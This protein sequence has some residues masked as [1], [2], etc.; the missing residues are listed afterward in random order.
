MNPTSKFATAPTFPIRLE[1]L[2]PLDHVSRL[3]RCRAALDELDL[4]ALLVTKLEHIRYLA[5][6]SGS[7]ALLL[8]GRERTTFVSDGRYDE[9]SR[10]QLGSAGIDADIVIT[11]DQQPVLT[12]AATGFRRIGLE[13]GAVTWAAQRRYGGEWFPDAELVPTEGVIEAW[14]VVKEVGEAA[15]ME[16]AAAIADR[17]LATL[18]PRLRDR[19]SEAEFALELDVAMR[20][21]GASGPAFETI[22]ASGANSSRPHH[23]PGP[24]P[25]G[26]DDL[27]VVDF[28]ATVD[29]YRSDMTRTVCVGEPTAEQRRLYDVVCEAQ[30]AGVAAVRAGREAKEVDAACRDIITAAGWGER[31]P[32]GTGHGVGLEIHEAP[33]VGRTSAATL[34]E[35]SVVTVEPGVYL[36]GIGGVRTEDSV[37]VTA[38]GCR[39]LTLFPKSLTF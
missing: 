1:D 17:A 21:L 28:G 34:T 24:R 20:R 14:R 29:G 3:E 37:V 25:I 18:L 13:A 11:V 39:P 5:G 22:V 33:H 38:E 27:V 32:H 8:V 30:A 7:A 15:R 31:F 10:Q 6:F 35:L 26:P 4:D 9:Q 19:P 23:R 2:P 12:Q 36:E 16:A